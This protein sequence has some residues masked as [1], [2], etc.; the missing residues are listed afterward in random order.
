MQGKERKSVKANRSP[1]AIPMTFGKL[2]IN[3]PQSLSCP[4]GVATALS[5]SDRPTA[6]ADQSMPFKF[7]NIE[8]PLHRGE[9]FVAK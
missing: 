7:Q 1:Q 2:A 3:W 6:L 9:Y 8:A 5:T 4:P